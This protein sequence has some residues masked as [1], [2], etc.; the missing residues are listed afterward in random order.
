MQLSN[1]LVYGQQLRCA[2]AAVAKGRLQ[3]AHFPLL[4]QRCGA[5][6]SLSQAAPAEAW[7]VRVLDPANPVVFVD[8]DTISLSQRARVSGT[9]EL[10]PDSQHAVEARLTELCV[11]ALLACGCQPP[12]IGVIT[13]FRNQQRAF[14]RSISERYGVEVST[15]DKFQGRDVKALVVAF[16]S[17]SKG[18]VGDLLR[19]WRRI[20]VAITR[21]RFKL[22]MLGSRTTTQTSPVMAELLETV[23]SRGWNVDMPE[24]LAR[25]EA[26]VTQV[27]NATTCS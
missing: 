5:S 10:T 18:C 15:I 26:I 4:V 16:G 19:D 17:T 14:R 23:Y 24:Q 6:A 12:D 20:N 22:I 25:E 1:T 21:A 11:R 7:L 27:L 8:T 2:N 9:Q 13:P 3:L